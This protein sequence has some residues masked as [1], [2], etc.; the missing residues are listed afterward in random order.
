MSSLLLGIGSADPWTFASV[1]VLLLGVAAV[2]CYLPARRAMNLDPVA[3][4][5]QD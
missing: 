2:A 5:R 1:A 4:L 3:A